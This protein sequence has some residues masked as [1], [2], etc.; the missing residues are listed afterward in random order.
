MFKIAGYLRPSLEQD[1]ALFC[2]TTK[3]GFCLLSAQKNEVSADPALH[4]KG[5]TG[6]EQA[7]G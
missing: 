3:Q 1:K 6:P 5:D 2:C 7:E 4:T